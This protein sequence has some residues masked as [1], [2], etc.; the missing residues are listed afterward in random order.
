MVEEK[1]LGDG[2]EGRGDHGILH[3]LSSVKATPL[4]FFIKEGGGEGG[5]VRSGGRGDRDVKLRRFLDYG[6]RG[7]LN[8][9][10]VVNAKTP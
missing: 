9:V 10:A 1:A 7:R 5:G 2:V 3:R 8:S 6:G 4:E